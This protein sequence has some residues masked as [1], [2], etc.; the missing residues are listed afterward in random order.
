MS[1]PRWK[2]TAQRHVQTQHRPSSSPQQRGEWEQIPPY[3]AQR[4]HNG[5]CTQSSEAVGTTAPDTAAS[6]IQKRTASYNAHQQQKRARERIQSKA[7]R[8]HNGVCTQFSER[9]R[10]QLCQTPQHRP[11]TSAT[12]ER[13][14]ADTAVSSNSDC[15]LRGYPTAKY[16][17]KQQP[18]SKQQTN[19]N[20]TTKRESEAQHRTTQHPPRREREQIPPY[21]ATQAPTTAHCIRNSVCT[22]VTAGADTAEPD[23]APSNSSNQQPRAIESIQPYESTRLHHGVCTQLAVRERAQ[24]YQTPQHPTL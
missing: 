6:Y 3:P 20:T 7:T 2:P 11:I 5:V 8:T 19:L 24:S 10:A 15:N 23:I 13:A 21:P 12:R 9:E 22:Q 1:S 4:T 17:S 18:N 16:N 14:R